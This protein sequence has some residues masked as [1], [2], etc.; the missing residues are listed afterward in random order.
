ML[1]VSSALVVPV[2]VF[3][4]VRFPSALFFFL[5]EELEEYD[6]L[7][8]ADIGKFPQ[9]CTIVLC[10]QFFVPTTYTELIG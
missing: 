4:L 2:F 9:F 3:I 8:Q 7:D 10:G 6:V 1:R 5:Q